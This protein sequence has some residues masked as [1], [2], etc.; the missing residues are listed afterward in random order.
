MKKL[1]YLVAAFLV[2][3]T[4]CHKETKAERYAREASET[5]RQCPMAVDANTVMDS[6]VYVKHENGFSY[7]YIVND[8][9][10]SVLLANQAMFKSQILDRLKN[11]LDMRPYLLDSMTF[12]YIYRTK[13]EGQPLM[14]F[15]Y[16]PDMY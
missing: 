16:T 15:T 13:P 10:D 14:S 7:Y 6:M 8:I 1:L 9:P 11:S 2:L 3:A 4:A 12:R 5:T